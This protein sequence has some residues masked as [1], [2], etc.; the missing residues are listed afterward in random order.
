MVRLQDLCWISEVEYNCALFEIADS[1]AKPVAVPRHGARISDVYL[2][3]RASRSV[4]EMRQVDS[5]L[6]NL[7]IMHRDPALSLLH[8]WVRTC[9]EKNLS[10]L[11][12]EYGKKVR[13]MDSIPF[14]TNESQFSLF[15]PNP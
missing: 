3:L 1:D 15:R 4:E 10:Q 8:S 13:V 9:D 14:C 6:S 5:Y 2:L 7:I 11:V 12:L